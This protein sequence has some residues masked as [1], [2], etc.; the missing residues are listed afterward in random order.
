MSVQARFYVSGYERNA[1]NADA[2]TVKL[3]AVTRGEHNK[4]WASATP[5]G[6]ITMTINNAGAAE[7]FVGQLGKEIAVTFE[8]APAEES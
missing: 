2:T 7:W 8:P 6:Q 5:N 3:Q 1:Y 4:N